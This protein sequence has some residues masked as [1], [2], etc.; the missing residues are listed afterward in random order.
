MT[1]L[2]QSV[3]LVGEG[4][5]TIFTIPPCKV[6]E[7]WEQAEDKYLDEIRFLRG[8]LVVEKNEKQAIQQMLMRALRLDVGG[9]NPNGANTELAQNKVRGIVS[10]M[11]QRAA[12]EQNSKVE[13]WRKKAE[14]STPLPDSVTSGVK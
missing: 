2:K 12:A 11:K 1:G 4:I 10:P 5:K 13:Y 8:Q 6:C 14:T 9:A 3:A 7:H